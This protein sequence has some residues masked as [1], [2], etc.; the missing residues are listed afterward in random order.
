MH[1]WI[2]V[3]RNIIALFKFYQAGAEKYDRERLMSKEYLVTDG[4]CEQ[5]AGLLL[6]L[7]LLMWRLEQGNPINRL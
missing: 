1:D 3:V 6:W 7:W 5:E 4:E 2:G